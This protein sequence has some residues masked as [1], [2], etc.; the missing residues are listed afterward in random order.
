MSNRYTK[1]REE[2]EHTIAKR[3]PDLAR[4]KDKNPVGEAVVALIGTVLVIFLFGLVANVRL[5]ANELAITITALVVAGVRY[6]YVDRMTKNYFSE[7]DRE[8]EKLEGSNP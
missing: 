5:T 1:I 4:F 7:L 6:F 8:I 2:A 3:L